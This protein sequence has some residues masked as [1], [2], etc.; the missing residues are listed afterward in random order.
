MLKI[1]Y[2]FLVSLIIIPLALPVP[3]QAAHMTAHDIGVNVPG[4]QYGYDHM[5]EMNAFLNDTGTRFVRDTFDLQLYKG[6][7]SES[8]YSG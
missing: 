7:S 1:I 5:S 4:I 3:L 8:W 6:S 2:A